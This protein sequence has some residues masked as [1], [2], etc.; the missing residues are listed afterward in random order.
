LFCGEPNQQGGSKPKTLNMRPTFVFLAAFMMWHQT[1][2]EPTVTWIADSPG[3]FDVVLSGTG[4]GWSGAIYSPSGLWRLWTENTVAQYQ[5]FPGRSDP[6]VGVATSAAAVYLGQLPPWYPTPPPFYPDAPIP[7][8]A[9]GAD[10]TSPSSYFDMFEP[11]A[12]IIDGNALDVGY[13]C[14][15]SNILPEPFLDWYGLC[16]ITVSSIPDWYDPSTWVW[17]SE[18]HASG[19]P[20]PEPSVLPLG[21]L[22]WLAAR[23][24]KARAGKA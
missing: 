4:P 10:L 5:I 22:V 19:T 12:P 16:H 20:I 1:K 2:A 11:V 9:G 17:S 15:Y 3:S 24:C 21:A 14:G 23:R 6:L 7:I 18:F 8:M 13:L